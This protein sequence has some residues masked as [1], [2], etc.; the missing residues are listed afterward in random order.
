[1]IS[2]PYRFEHCTTSIS[3]EIYKTTG[4]DLTVMGD[5]IQKP[6]IHILN[7][8]CLTRYPLGQCGGDEIV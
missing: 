5:T 8:N 7:R 1:M 2:A 6:S 3:L 4:T